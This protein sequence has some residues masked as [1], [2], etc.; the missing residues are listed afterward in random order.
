MAGAGR[1]AGVGAAI[2]PTSCTVPGEPN[3]LPALAGLPPTIDCP[4]LAC[5]VTP[6]WPCGSFSETP[7]KILFFNSDE[8]LLLKIPEFAIFS[9]SAC[10][11]DSL[12]LA[13]FCSYKFSKTEILDS[14]SGLTDNRPCTTTSPPPLSPSE[15]SAEISISPPVVPAPLAVAP[16]ASIS[17][18]DVSSTLA[19]PRK[20]T[21]PFSPM[22]A[23]LA[24]MRPLFLTRPP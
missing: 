19:L 5:C 11:I 2:C 12:T 3:G 7:G 14:S 4:K 9:I 8:I 17:L 16:V 24:W 13:F 20:T 6:A 1:G 15:L 21:L 22:M 18:V 10:A 23:E